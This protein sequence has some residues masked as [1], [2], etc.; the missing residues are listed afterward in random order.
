MVASVVAGGL[1]VVVASLV[2]VV[3]TPVVV[4]RELDL[5]GRSGSSVVPYRCRYHSFREA[6]PAT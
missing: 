1:A 6:R 5:K 3:G 2:V 4:G